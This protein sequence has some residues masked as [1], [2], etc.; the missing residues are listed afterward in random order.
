[1]GEHCTIWVIP[2]AKCNTELIHMHLVIT[3]FHRDFSPLLRTNCSYCF[4]LNVF[5]FITHTHWKWTE[6]GK[7]DNPVSITASSQGCGFFSCTLCETGLEH[8]MNTLGAC[9]PIDP[10]IKSM[11]MSTKKKNKV[12]QIQCERTGNTNHHSKITH[13]QNL[14]CACTVS[15]LSLKNLIASLCGFRIGQEVDLDKT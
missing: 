9:P 7:Y 4:G 11:Q 12:H 8:H 13:K 15:L 2:K 3:F 1:M 6:Q 14:Y 5:Y 10:K